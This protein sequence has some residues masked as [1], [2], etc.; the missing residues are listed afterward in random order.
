MGED[1]YGRHFNR[2]VDSQPHNVALVGF[3]YHAPPPGTSP[4]HG[5]TFPRGTLPVDSQTFT[6]GR[7]IGLTQSDGWT[8]SSMGP[9]SSPTSTLVRPDPNKGQAISS[10]LARAP[11]SGC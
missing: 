8:I 6:V 9:T 2:S 7:H 3:L 4:V 10:G 1:G 5:Q 11:T